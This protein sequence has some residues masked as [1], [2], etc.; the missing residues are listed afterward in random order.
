MRR[1]IPKGSRDLKW[2]RISRLAGLPLTGLARKILH[3][4]KVMDKPKIGL[5]E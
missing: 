1:A 4:L 3:R 5:L 2:T